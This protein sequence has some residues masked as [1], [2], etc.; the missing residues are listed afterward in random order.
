MTPL[1]DHLDD[2]AA[3]IRGGKGLEA[4]SELC[5]D[6]RSRRASSALSEWV[7]F[8][9]ACR[10][11]PI[12]ELLLQDPYTARAFHK[13]R[14][15][16]GDAEMLDYVYTQ[17]PPPGTT[18]IGSA[19]FRAT[20]GLPNGQS[21]VDRRNL[22]AQ[23]IDEIAAARPNAKILSIACGHLR[24]AQVGTAISNGLIKEFVAF[25]QDSISLEVVRREQSAVGV[26]TIQGSIA[27][28]IRRRV[29]FDHFDLV[30]AAG[31]FDYLTDLFSQRL[32][33]LMIGMLRPCGRLLV[34]NFTP[35]NHG[36]GYMECF[37]DWIL[38]CRNEDQMASLLQSVDATQIK[39]QT[40]Y[41][42][43]LRNIVYLEIEKTQRMQCNPTE[44]HF[45]E[46]M[47]Q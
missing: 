20:T 33:A 45:C 11:H 25:D 37:M 26:Q 16:A 43:R 46:N 47:A 23:R 32:L 7:Q 5:D 8:A 18:A 2:I 1:N 3:R 41:R 42:D 39:S 38:T 21:V 34:A 29:S 40:V 44:K 14:G 19:V 35:D 9:A 13:P 24:E 22:L 12:H 17:V 28:I 27:D 31:L 30:Y 15:Y 10:Q 4:V 36:R 6:L